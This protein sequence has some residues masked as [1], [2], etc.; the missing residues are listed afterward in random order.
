MME[1]AVQS[2]CLKKTD[3]HLGEIPKQDIIKREITELER[4]I[5]RYKS[6][7]LSC[8]SRPIDRENLINAQAELYALDRQLASL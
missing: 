2:I 4:K 1:K 6:A 5:I 8:F 7:C 3:V